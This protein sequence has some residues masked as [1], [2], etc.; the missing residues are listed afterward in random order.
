[1]VT[2]LAYIARA[3]CEETPSNIIT[4]QEVGWSRSVPT[5]LASGQRLC[6]RRDTP[7][8]ATRPR[9]IGQ[10]GPGGCPSANR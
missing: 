10:V 4:Q 1:M 7:V 9:I 5:V 3:R 2:G 8:P 6:Q